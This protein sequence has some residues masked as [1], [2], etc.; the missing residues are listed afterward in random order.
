MGIF[1]GAVVVYIRALYYP[2]GFNFPL[3]LMSNQVAATELIREFASLV[4]LLSVG[5]IA[6]KNFSQRL[7][8]FIYSFAVWDIIYY[9]FLFLILAWPENLF[10]WDILFLLPVTWTGPVIAPVIISILMIVLAMVLYSHNLKSDFKTKLVQKEWFI[11]IVGS[12]IVFISFIWDYCKFI[13]QNYEKIGDNE[14]V[15]S[16][17]IYNLSFQYI[18]DRFP[19]LIFILGVIIIGAGIFLVNQRNKKSATS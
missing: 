4:M 7:A 15:I 16:T 1:E 6:G 10:T 13:V 9:V 19:W 5:V 18:P 17:K 12:I 14:Q 2:E 11:L 8:W 3:K